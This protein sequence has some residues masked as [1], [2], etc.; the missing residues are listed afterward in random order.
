[1]FLDQD[2]I[3]ANIRWLRANASEPVRHLTHRHLLEEDPQS[4]LMAARWRDVRII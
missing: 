1:M 2:Q 3:D 4:E